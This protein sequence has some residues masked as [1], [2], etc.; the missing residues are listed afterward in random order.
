MSNNNDVDEFSF[1]ASI[2]N[3]KNN[4][5]N[6]TLKETNKMPLELTR[7]DSDTKITA[8]TTNKNIPKC[9]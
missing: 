2:E 8:D 6:F 3:N 1:F 4:I 5:S 9:L 7:I